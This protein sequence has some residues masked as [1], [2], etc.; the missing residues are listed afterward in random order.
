MDSSS[1]AHPLVCV[2]SHRHDPV[3]QPHVRHSEH[4]PFVDPYDV[5]QGSI[6]A[7]TN[8]PALRLPENEFVA[9]TWNVSGCTRSSDRDLIDQ[10]LKSNQIAIACLQETRLASC[11][12][13]TESY[14][15]FNVNCQSDTAPRMGGG[16]SVLV[17]RGHFPEG[18]D[19][20]RVSDNICGVMI[21]VFGE[22]FIILSVYAR[23]LGNRADPELSVLTHYLASLSERQRANL[24]V[25]GDFN[26]H[27]GLHDLLP[28]DRVRV[29]SFLYHQQS[30]PNGEVLKELL[31]FHNY[32]LTSSFG[33]D[34]SVVCTWKRGSRRSQVCK[35][36][37][38]CDLV[39]MIYCY[40]FTWLTL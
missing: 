11:A 37:F 17:H 35:I 2:P 40:S 24:A 8:L 39:M 6:V 27:I 29:G 23:S 13:I 7:P 20:F 4:Q 33:P 12:L 14:S 38:R 31:H 34:R 30:N 9:G 15:W 18:G 10:F 3:P 36:M 22:Q 19:F 1:L 5:T 28:A 16:T 25:L 32:R 21:N 26:A